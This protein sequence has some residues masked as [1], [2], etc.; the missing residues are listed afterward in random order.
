MA[1]YD[2]D[3]TASAAVTAFLSQFTLNANGNIRYSSG[4]DTFHVKWLHVAL[5]KKVWDFSTSGDDNLN[6]AKPNPSTSAALG[7]IITLLDQTTDY[8]V[9]YNITD[10][11]AEYFFGGSI[12]QQNISSQL[13]RYSGL[14]VLGSVNAGTT[15]L[16]VLQDGALLTS[17]WSTGKNQ[18]DSSTLLRILVKTYT[19]GAETD[20][21]IVVVKASEWGDTFALWETTL[22][23]GEKVAAVNTASDPQNNT[24]QATVEAYTGYAGVAVTLEGYDQI[25]VDGNGADNFLGTASYASLTGNQNPK[26]LF[27]VVKAFLTRGTTDT[28]FGMDGDLW[29]GRVYDVA[30][31][32][33]AGGELWV[34]NETI[35]WS[36]TNVGTG[37]L[38]AVDATGDDTAVRMILHITT[39]I[40][41]A[42]GDTLAGAAASQVVNGTPVKLTTATNI[43]GLYTGSNWIGATGIGFSGSELIFG[44]SVTSLDGQTP[45]VPQNVTITV[46]VT[47]NASGH[48]PH[49]F[50]AVKDA[51]LT[52]PDYTTL[53]SSTGNTAADPDFVVAEAIP[54]DT[55]QDGWF[56]VLITGQTQYKFYHYESWV[57]STFTLDTTDHAGG[58]DE[59]VTS[60]DAVF[61]AL[62]YTSAVGGGTAK[63]IANTYVYSADIDV[64]GWVRNGDPSQPDSPIP[65]S[66]SVGSGGQ[67]F[68]VVLSA[69]S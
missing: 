23:L 30:M 63:T 46:N 69:E 54:S 49:V 25:D 26:A 43:L 36:G 20:Q 35:S 18:T 39:G 64:I 48:D 56:G 3:A 22:G 32:A 34:Q 51:A 41:P 42:S 57:G 59:T 27:E 28:V 31:T 52:A 2:S 53:T 13:E 40:F 44:D 21:S 10:N 4:S 17:H 37:V 29:T 16:Q 55:P 33:G 19:A 11:D 9:R 68:S 8:G 6:M 61:V 66:G 47:A 60:T 50:L 15:E 24:S 38:M 1:V 14:V 5:Q 45:T 65:I 58:L 12:E 7:T 62:L 67:T